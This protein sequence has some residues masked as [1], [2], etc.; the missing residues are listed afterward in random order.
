[1]EF[2]DLEKEVLNWVAKS[3]GDENL[4]EQIGHAQVKE[5][6]QSDDGIFIELTYPKEFKAK[7]LTTEVKNPIQGPGI[8]STN[9]KHQGSSLVFVAD[10]Y[11]SV[12][13]I[14]SKDEAFPK[15]ICNFNLC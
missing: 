10:G 8:K 14:F 13:E 1:M 5:R 9:L 2:S 4:I 11:A 7:S 3:S 15:E 12:L 6:E